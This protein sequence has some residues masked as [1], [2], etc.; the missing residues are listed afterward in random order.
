MEHM[1]LSK[2]GKKPANPG[3]FQV[4]LD[5]DTG[6]HGHAQTISNLWVHLDQL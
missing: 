6:K 1:G 4:E 3:F 2:L 5:A